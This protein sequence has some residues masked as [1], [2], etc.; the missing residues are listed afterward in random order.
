MPLP[1]ARNRTFEQS[2]VSSLFLRRTQSNNS[3]LSST[4][5]KNFSK[6]ELYRAATQKKGN[7]PISSFAAF[8]NLYKRRQGPLAK[9]IRTVDPL[10]YAQSAAMD[11]SV[12]SS[13]H[14]TSPMKKNLQ[15]IPGSPKSYRGGRRKPG[16][17]GSLESS[18]HHSLQTSPLLKPV[19]RTTAAAERSGPSYPNDPNDPNDPDLPSTMPESDSNTVD[20]A[21]NVVEQDP[22][23]GWVKEATAIPIPFNLSSPSTPGTVATPNAALAIDTASASSIVQAVKGGRR[24]PFKIL[25]SKS[26]KSMCSS[27]RQT[28]YGTDQTLDSVSLLPSW[29]KR[30]TGTS[31]VTTIKGDPLV[32]LKTE[33]LKNKSKREKSAKKSRRTHNKLSKHKINYN[34]YGNA[35]DKSR[36]MES[37][38]AL[39]PRPLSRSGKNQSATGGGV[40]AIIRSRPGTGASNADDVWSNEILPWNNENEKLETGRRNV[41]GVTS[42]MATQV[43][44]QR[45]ASANN[46]KHDTQQ[47]HRTAATKQA[48]TKVTKRLAAAK[49]TSTS[50]RINISVLARLATVNMSFEVN[51]KLLTTSSNGWSEIEIGDELMTAMRAT[52]DRDAKNLLD[53]SSSRN[54]SFDWQDTQGEWQPLTSGT[55]MKTAVQEKFHNLSLVVPRNKRN[56]SNKGLSLLIRMGP[57]RPQSTSTSRNG[58][59]MEQQR[60]KTL[61]IHDGDVGSRLLQSRGSLRSRNSGLSRGSSRQ[62]LSRNMNRD[63]VQSLQSSTKI[64]GGGSG[65]RK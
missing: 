40:M 45:P 58:N 15:S 12:H 65:S 49:R 17:E 61:S 33:K 56:A 10:E 64:K 38:L 41:N 39:M 36:N 14:T 20:S 37:R 26:T 3:S 24:T 4:L 50:I 63:V 43:I 53:V 32:S 60:P 19:L 31:Y 23:A 59:A 52:L 11:S 22:N 28:T 48:A 44:D 46:N 30:T 42:V 16:A 1:P 13:T 8:P 18:L 5:T 29:P 9:L 25:A 35:E 62:S 51:S 7:K 47:Q 34:T 6:Q 54:A 55:A 57:K 21:W 27:N 2:F